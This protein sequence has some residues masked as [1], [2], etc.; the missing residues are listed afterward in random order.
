MRVANLITE[1]RFPEPII[2]E[3]NWRG[4][5]IYENPHLKV[6]AVASDHTIPCF[7][8]AMVEKTG[9]HPEPERLRS[10]TLRPGKWVQ[11]TLE[12]LRAEAS[13]NTTLEIDG[14]RFTLA[15]LRDTYFT[16]TPGSRI[17]FVTDTLWS[18]AVQPTL[19]QLARGASQLYCDSYYSIQ[20]QRQ[21]D[22]HRH[23]TAAHAAELACQAKVG[24]LILMH[25]GPRY[26]GNYDRLVEEARAIFPRVRA[27]IPGERHS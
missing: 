7:A 22:K 10:G 19:V 13:P 12:L 8:Y 27:D 24:E 4:K 17:A 5:V 2:E 1:E 14:G 3:L 9:Y 6:E 20:E 11:E 25:F 21:A 18:E 26:K 16:R 23:M 15:V